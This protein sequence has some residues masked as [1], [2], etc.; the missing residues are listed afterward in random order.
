MEA[1]LTP[2]PCTPLRPADVFRQQKN[3]HVEDGSKD[4]D[5]Q[6]NTLVIDESEDDD[7]MLDGK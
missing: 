2:S 3:T 4:D 6:K 5:V 7:M 1:R